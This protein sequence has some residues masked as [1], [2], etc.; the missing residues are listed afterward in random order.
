MKTS[1]IIASFKRKCL[2]EQ[3]GLKPCDCSH[4]IHSRSENELPYYICKIDAIYDEEFE[5]CDGFEEVFER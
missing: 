2:L 3:D 1:E 4:C 5:M